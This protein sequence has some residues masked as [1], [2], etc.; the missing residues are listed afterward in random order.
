MDAYKH[1]SVASY[2]FAYY[3]ARATDQEIRKPISAACR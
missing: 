1:F 3:A 2:M